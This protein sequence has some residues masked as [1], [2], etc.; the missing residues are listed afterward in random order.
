MILLI[1]FSVPATH[2][3]TSSWNDSIPLQSPFF[4]SNDTSRNFENVLIMNILQLS[5]II[6]VSNRYIVAWTR[7]EKNIVQNIY[8][9]IC[10]YRTV[11]GKSNLE[12]GN[13]NYRILWFVWRNNEFLSSTTVEIVLLELY[14]REFIILET[15]LFKNVNE[16]RISKLKFFHRLKGLNS[17]W[18]DATSLFYL[19]PQRGYFDNWSCRLRAGLSCRP[20]RIHNSDV[21]TFLLE[22]LIGA[23]WK[24]AKRNKPCNFELFRLA[25]GKIEGRRT[26]I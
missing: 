14:F 19:F 16:S 20:L 10:I 15:N 9:F 18:I 23:I 11:G 5:R 24:F 4:L 2:R 25:N 1:L 22:L 12:F 6:I 21:E 7:W 8:D 13:W 17:D 26:E 3:V